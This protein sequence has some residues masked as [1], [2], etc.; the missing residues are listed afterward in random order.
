MRKIVISIIFILFLVYFIDSPGI[1]QDGPKKEL[2]G[3]EIRAAQ[4]AEV[5]VIED[6]PFRELQELEA[7][8]DKEMQWLQAETYVITA[9][10]VLEDISK[11]AALITVITDKQIRQMGA[12]DL[13][14]IL[15]S[16]PGISYQNER[17]GGVD[18]DVR[19]IAKDADQHI[20]FLMNSYSLNTNY[21]G[22]I[23]P[24]YL[25]ITVD[26][27]KRV[28][29]IRGP[30]SSLYGSN[31]FA[32]IV[33]IITYE[34][35]DL[36][37]LQ[38]TAR[39]GNFETAQVNALFGKTFGEVGIALDFDYSEYG[40]YQGYIEQ[41]V[42][43]ML[44]LIFGSNASLAP[45]YTRESSE[46]LDF[47][48]TLRYKGLRFDGRYADRERVPSIGISPVLNNHSETPSTD[49][50][51]GLSYTQDV[52]T[53]VNL[54]GKVYHNYTHMDY[55]YQ[56]YPEGAVL[57]TTDGQQVQ[58]EVWP[59]GLI[60]APSNK[61]TRTGA[62]LQT[63]VLLHESNTLVGGVTYEYMEQ[64]DVKALSNYLATPIKDVVIPRGEVSE[65][66][67]IQNYNRDVSR[68]FAALFLED[69]WDIREDL[70]LTL[71]ARYDDYSDVS[72]SFNPRA[73]LVWEYK[74]GYDMKALYG[75][76]FRAPNFYELY[77][78]NNPAFVGNPDLKPETVDTYEL[79]LGA[80]FTPSFNSRIT[81]FYNIIQD[82]IDLATYETQDV[83]E[84]RSEIRTSG[85]EFEFKYDIGRGTYL[86]MNYTYQDSKNQDTGEQPYNVPK[87]KGN[88]MANIRFSKHLNFY[89]DLYFQKGF[90]RQ[91]DD[92]REED[93]PGFQVINVTLI[94]GKFIP[95][96]A[97]LELRGSVYN[98]F[99]LDYTVPTANDGLSVDFPM[100]GRSFLV[101]LRYMFE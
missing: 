99:D 3:S 12:R 55:Y 39:G 63:T 101:G 96:L 90:T 34:A 100:P 9:S 5:S 18:Y 84:N 26:N 80:Q 38:I 89:T 30:A 13:H 92:I 85:I 48:L 28:E 61:N 29:V 83:F 42:Q 62:E 72:G 24:S 47:M 25:P 32:A 53:G 4:E 56:V 1:A 37:G 50:A 60:G 58:P 70:R 36:D 87:H 73:G 6:D 11:S 17:H 8:V 27:I 93:N 51:L 67:H 7:S 66:S 16:V 68:R 46:K 33:N 52:A 59:E 40:S 15:R 44:D 43:T 98:V 81:G 19:G 65:V 76:A 14:D 95:K 10:K 74:Q 97:G 86:G 75:R 22:G 57:P 35:E 77:N 64:Y 91:K 71:G 21:W 82:S 88:L 41:D 23:G 49:Y 20:L 94:G 69:L 2:Q 79:S 45:G 78:M 54:L 31:A